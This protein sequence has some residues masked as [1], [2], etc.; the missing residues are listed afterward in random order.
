MIPIFHDTLPNVLPFCPA[1]K[2]HRLTSVIIN[3]TTS[4]SIIIRPRFQN[5]GPM[6]PMS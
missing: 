1:T 3:I 4:M 6:I 5:K 2:M